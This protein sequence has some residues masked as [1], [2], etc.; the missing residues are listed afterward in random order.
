MVSEA[1]A[2]STRRK[3]RKLKDLYLHEKANRYG[4]PGGRLNLVDLMNFCSAGFALGPAFTARG[5]HL[6]PKVI[7]VIFTAIA[8]GACIVGITAAEWRLMP[9]AVKDDTGGESFREKVDHRNWL[10]EFSWWLIRLFLWSG[11]SFGIGRL[12][13]ILISECL[14][15][16]AATLPGAALATCQG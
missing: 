8:F 14:G 1:R 4:L 11:I 7:C 10:T 3:V 12:T 2:G 13:V 16:L 15:T 9:L 6:F 5:M